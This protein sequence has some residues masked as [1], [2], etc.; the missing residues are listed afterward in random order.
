[1]TA[2]YFEEKEVSLT[3]ALLAVIDNAHQDIPL[4]AVLHSIIGDMSAEELAVIRANAEAGM[5]FYAALS[6]EAEIDKGSKAAR[7]LEKLGRC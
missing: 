7:F 3:L 2:G 4:A 1:M 5:D 6:R